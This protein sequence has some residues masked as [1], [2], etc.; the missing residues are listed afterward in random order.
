MHLGTKSCLMRRQL[1]LDFHGLVVV[2]LWCLQKNRESRG[3]NASKVS[4][5]VQCRFCSQHG[6]R[7]EQGARKRSHS[8]LVASR[9]T[10]VRLT[11][12]RW[13]MVL[14]TCS[15]RGSVAGRE[16]I[17]ME[18]TAPG[19]R[20]GKNCEKGR[21]YSNTAGLDLPC[22]I[23]LFPSSGCFWDPVIV[24]VVCLPQTWHFP[25][26]FHSQALILDFFT[27]HVTFQGHKFFAFSPQQI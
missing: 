12:G 20:S 23:M 5:A 17:H 11:G 1:R 16:A 10:R 3:A 15:S 21:G 2:Y 24:L 18:I 7:R 25:Q 19:P 4:V 27:L 26:V 13:V 8:S 6:Q 14:V 22:C 9:L